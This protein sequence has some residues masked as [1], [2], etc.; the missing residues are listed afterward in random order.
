[1]QVTHAIGD[2]RLVFKQGEP[3]KPVTLRVHGDPISIIGKILDQNQRS[4]T[5]VNHFISIG[6]NMVSQSIALS[7]QFLDVVNLLRSSSSF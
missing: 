3:F 6:E 4:Y 5:K 7:E 1:M 2:Y